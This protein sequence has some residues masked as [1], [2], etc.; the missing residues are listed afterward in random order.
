MLEEYGNLINAKVLILGNSDRDFNS[1]DFTLPQSIRSVFAQ[2][3]NFIDKKMNVL[4][5]GLENL[6]LGVNGTPWLFNEKMIDGEKKRKVLIGPFFYTHK[7]RFEFQPL[8]SGDDLEIVTR[9]MSPYQYARF[10]SHYRFIAS[11]RGN[12]IDTHRFWESLYRGS[13]PIVK[14]N[15]W[16]NLISKLDIPFFEVESF[17][18]ESLSQIVKD[19][20][21]SSVW[22]SSIKSLWWPYWR[23]EISKCL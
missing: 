8:Q 13:L 4:P 9:R 10:S 5:I 6:R 15:T 20:N 12:G 17:S 23:H 19:F 22:P 2:N 16:S 3:L 7:E 14:K 1:F 18:S 21:N 11:P